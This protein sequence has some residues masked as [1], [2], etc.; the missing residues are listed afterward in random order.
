MNRRKIIELIIYT[1]LIVI[2]FIIYDDSIGEIIS[3]VIGFIIAKLGER[4]LEIIMWKMEDA[5]KISQTKFS[6]EEATHTIDMNIGDKELKLWYCPSVNN[7]N[8]KY[9]IV[10]RCENTYALDPLIIA[11]YT[12]IME[13]HKYSYIEN[14]NMIRLDDVVTDENE[15]KVTLYTSRTKFYNDLVTNRA[16]DYAFRNDITVRKL[17]ENNR[18]ISSYK[19]SKM[20]NHIGINAMV[21][22]GDELVF[23]LRGGSA[24]ISKGKVTSSIAIGLSENLVR[25]MNQTKGEVIVKPKDVEEKVII[26]KLAKAFKTSMEHI[27]RLKKTRAIKIYFLGFGQL[28]YSGGKPQFYYAVAVDKDAIGLPNAESFMDKDRV[29]YNKNYIMASKFTLKK[30]DTNILVL[31]RKGRRKISVKAERSFFANYWHLISQPKKSGI[32]EWIYELGMG[33]KDI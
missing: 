30:D 27:E 26:E 1:V 12:D 14:V 25:T 29:D 13:A 7:S 21:F 33:E 22:Y 19:D 10:D 24:T 16:M 3:V 9:E 4:I 23:P 31:H 8:A 18:T 6:Y 17:F 20:S 11:N 2:A 15:D 28:I 5:N 32:P